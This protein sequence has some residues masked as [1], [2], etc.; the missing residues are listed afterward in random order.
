[1]AVFAKRK[2]TG[3]PKMPMLTGKPFGS[4]GAPW[5]KGATPIGP[6]PRPFVPPAA[7]APARTPPSWL[8]PIPPTTPATGMVA[9]VLGPRAQRQGLPKWLTPTSGA[10]TAPAAGM[11][12][13]IVKARPKTLKPRTKKFGGAGSPGTWPGLPKS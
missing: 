3:T 1:M 12:A 7:T 13:K 6:A 11:P 8:K 4:S 5:R 2:M 10:P 9:R